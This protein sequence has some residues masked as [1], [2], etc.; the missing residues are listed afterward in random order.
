[1]TAFVELPAEQGRLLYAGERGS[2]HLGPGECSL[3]AYMADRC[4]QW[5]EGLLAPA[6][7]Q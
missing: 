3:L 4:R 1:M 6:A 2:V 5:S 7:R